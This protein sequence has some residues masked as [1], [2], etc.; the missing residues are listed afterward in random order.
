[1]TKV[2]IVE[3]VEALEEYVEEV[4]ETLPNKLDKRE[5]DDTPTLD[6]EGL[7]TSDGIYRAL[8]QKQDNLIVDFQLSNV[9][10]NPIANS[11]VATEINA[12]RDRI[13]QVSNASKDVPRG[14]KLFTASG[15][16]VV[17]AKVKALKVICVGAGGGGTVG[18]SGGGVAGGTGVA[19]KFGRYVTANG[20]GGAYRRSG[21]GGGGYSCTADFYIGRKGDNGGY[22]N[23][24]VAKIWD[25]ALV[26]VLGYGYGGGGQT[27]GGAGASVVAWINNL[28]P[29]ES[30]VVTV[31]NGG[32]G[33]SSGLGYGTAGGSGFCVVEW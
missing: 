30:I 32:A 3:R 27:G 31:G 20:G 25:N 11:T 16:F 4:K 5:I 2:K 8:A 23:I 19:T 14:G 28:T 26:E 1:M 33:G 13:E 29:G 15:I 7:V 10:L 21:G 18:D 17:P 6:S 22:G 24:P 9:S 12:V